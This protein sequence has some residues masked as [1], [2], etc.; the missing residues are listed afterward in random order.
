MRSERA[1]KSS[2]ESE[3][4]LVTMPVPLNMEI[5]NI[6]SEVI[7]VYGVSGARSGTPISS[8]AWI[9]ADATPWK[10]EK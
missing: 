9:M 1:I 10:C 3:G 8:V 5:D 6:G 2:G 4:T 7:V